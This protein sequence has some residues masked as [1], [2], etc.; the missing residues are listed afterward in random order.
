[1]IIAHPRLAFSNE[2]QKAF[3]HSKRKG[4]A[5]RFL[6]KIEMR[7]VVETPEGSPERCSAEAT[8]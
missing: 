7:R 6:H 8:D 5:N 1:M 4:V 2:K 3:F